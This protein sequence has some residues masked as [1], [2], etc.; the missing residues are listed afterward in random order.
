MACGCPVMKV[1]KLNG[2][3]ADFLYALA[4]DRNTVRKQAEQSFNPMVT[5]A[6]FKR[7]LDS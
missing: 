5:A 4:Q 2:Y 3:D 7:I 1:S 6:M